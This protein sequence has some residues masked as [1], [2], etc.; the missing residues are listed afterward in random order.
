[1]SCLAQTLRNRWSHGV[2]LGTALGNA[3]FR[4][5]N[6]V[7]IAVRQLGRQQVGGRWRCHG[8][9]EPPPPPPPVPQKNNAEKK[10]GVVLNH[11][12]DD[13]TILTSWRAED[14][15]SVR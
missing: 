12:D 14:L 2:P 8:R 7:G 9:R 3:G 6:R 4:E 5:T 1:M 15:P 11:D 10:I 13:V